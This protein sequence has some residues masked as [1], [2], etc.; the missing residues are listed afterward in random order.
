VNFYKKRDSKRSLSAFEGVFIPSILTIFGVIM[1]LRLGWVVGQ[2]GLINALLIITLASLI[3]FI[4]GFSIASIAT[5]MEVKTGGAY[6]I[7]SRSLGLSMGGAI[8]LPLYLSQ[9]LSIPLYIFGFAE[10]LKLIFPDIQIQ[11]IA[12]I[13]ALVIFFLALTGAKFAIRFQYLIFIVIILSLISYFAGAINF[14][15]T[16]YSPVLFSKSGLSFWHVFAVYFP[17]VT[18]ILAGVSMS[19]DLKNPQFAIPVGTL[20]AIVIGFIVYFLMALYLPFNAL[21]EELLNN[22]LI[23]TEVAKW[24]ILVILGIWGATLSSAIGSMLSAPR[25]IQALSRD[26]ILPVF[27]GKGYGKQDE[28]IPGT[29]ITLILS[30]L[31]IVFGTINTIAPL[32]TI[33]FLT[34]YGMLNL[35]AGLETLIKSPHYRPQFHTPWYISLLGALACFITMFLIS[36]FSSLIS[37][38]TI[39]I[40]FFYLQKHRFLQNWRDISKSLWTS[41]IRFSVLKLQENKKYP[42]H[43]RP[44]ILV[45]PLDEE[46]QSDIIK[47]ANWIGHHTGSV[48]I[49][50]MITGK[51]EKNVRN[52]SRSEKKTESYLDNIGVNALNFST[53]IEDPVTDSA[54]IAQSAG[55][56][57]YKPNTVIFPWQDLGHFEQNKYVS[58]IRNQFL[59]GKNILVMSTHPH[60]AFSDNQNIDIWWGGED[61]NIDLMLLLGHLLKLDV[62]WEKSDLNVYTI[63][64]DAAEKT[65]TENSMKE[66]LNS[67]RIKARINVIIKDERSIK[68]IIIENSIE[69]DLVFMGMDYPEKGK[70]KV[71]Y[72]SLKTFA[73]VFAVTVFVRNSKRSESAGEVINS[74]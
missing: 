57:E 44:N 3:S 33:F 58:M 74:D 42:G 30:L 67:A 21:T 73:D 37:L 25:T 69:S 49:C 54:I 55:L 60:L 62:H 64:N 36:V 51:I 56:G 11:L 61:K 45:F 43:W 50:K 4:T 46:K 34:T 8:G 70:E 38:I 7:L 48:M 12:L 22:D 41:I 15:N 17:A 68:D 24:P 2:A 23:I 63:I 31:A 65:N 28:P 18:G 29:V 19:G 1:Y 14:T 9:T 26:G 47:F 52:L 66:F 16:A 59:I 32:L 39:S 20:S 72:S 35:V 40:I 53:V 10:S 27:I 71:F 13:T 5:N 6:Y